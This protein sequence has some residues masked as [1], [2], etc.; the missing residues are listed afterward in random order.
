MAKAA[1]KA[2]A[3]ARAKA[4]PKARPTPPPTITPKAAPKATGKPTQHDFD[5]L[6]ARRV[7]AIGMINRARSGVGFSTKG[8]MEAAAKR[9]QA[10][11]DAINKEYQDMKQA[12]GFSGYGFF[13]GARPGYLSGIFSGWDR[14][15]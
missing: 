8:Q 7:R 1:P 10:A 6:K 12:T 5:A 13:S 15:M 9:A 11:F 2:A 3:A 14:I 4:A